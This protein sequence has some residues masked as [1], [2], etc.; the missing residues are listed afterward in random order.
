MVISLSIRKEF[1]STPVEPHI[2]RALLWHTGADLPG[3]TS[4][5][6]NPVTVNGVLIGGI[7]GQKLSTL[8]QLRVTGVDTFCNWV[9]IDN[10]LYMRF[11]TENE[12]P[13][14]ASAQDWMVTPR[15]M[16]IAYFISDKTFEVIGGQ[17]YYY[18][19]IGKYQM[20]ISAEP[21]DY[22]T[23][24]FNS[25]KLSL[26]RKALEEDPSAYL[27]GTM[28]VRDDDLIEIEKQY[29]E[30]IVY[31]FAL[32]TIECKDLR[33]KLSDNVI[34]QQ[35]NREEYRNDNDN[36]IMDEDTGKRYKSDAVGYCNGVPCDC[37]NGYAFE[38]QG[39]RR[40][41]ASYGTIVVDYEAPIENVRAG[42]GVEVEME[43]GW[44]V[45]PQGNPGED[46][47]WW[48]D[49][50]EEKLPSGL[51]ITT[52]LICV[53]NLVAH[54]PDSGYTLPDLERTPR[55]L[56]VTG[57]F[58]S[59]RSNI[60]D[61]YNIFLYLIERYSSIPWT[62]EDFNQ[63]EIQAELGLFSGHPMG[64]FIGE[65]E[66]LYNVIGLLQTGQ[67]YGWQFCQ[68]R[69]KLTARVF[70][71]NRPLFSLPVRTQDVLNLA[72]LKID[73]DGKNYV[74]T[75]VI[76]FNRLYSEDTA[77]EYFDEVKEDEVILLRSVSKRKEI[78]TLLKNEADAIIRY[79]EEIKD[80]I[81]IAR[82][83][84]GIKLSG[85][86]WY[87]LRQYDFL[88]LDMTNPKTGKS[89]FSGIVY[90]TQVVID[91]KTETVTIDVKEKV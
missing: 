27:G 21:H 84:K 70:N 53:P 17:A 22:Q 51:P 4:Y 26:L 74:S 65:P 91:I 23:L 39:S 41:R 20:K 73:L 33:E 10:Y 11:R 42:H 90:T 68:Y 29:V 77:S 82:V 69:G 36:I 30:N 72:E 48:Y 88:S 16:E 25:L 59:E 18:G 61:C 63:A 64:V 55:K 60:T 8:E 44:K 58:H 80:S 67:I 13:A 45:L 56:R 54:P 19:M 71:P 79:N 47:K 52:T 62:V 24:K 5:P 34:D 85:K 43:N 86:K 78:P 83:I 46:G 12:D 66:K 14:Y 35:F 49:S 81:N 32:V 38:T 7:T 6:K 50:I 1:V 15:N 37:L 75:M 76:Q 28:V 40:Y 87:G 89:L 2:W 57:T 31:D 9:Q 3:H